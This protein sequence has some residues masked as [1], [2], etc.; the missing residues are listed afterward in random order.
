LLMW[1]LTVY[2]HIDLP[3]PEFPKYSSKV[4]RLLQVYTIPRGKS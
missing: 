4:K 3:S 2:H 1:E